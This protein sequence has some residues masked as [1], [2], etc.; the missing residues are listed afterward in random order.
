MS[1][2]AYASLWHRLCT[3]NFTRRRLSRAALECFAAEFASRERALVVHCVDIDHRRHFPNSFVVS[4]RAGTEPDLRADPAYACLGSIEEGS[5]GLI[6]CT[7]LLEHIAEPAKLVAQ[8]A[9][10]LRP[11][12]R[13]VLSA[14]AVFPF[15]GAPDNFYHYTPNGFRYLFRDWR[16]ISVLR[17]SSGPFL[18][19]AILLQRIN[20]QCEVFPAVRL[21]NEVLFR[22][23]PPLD[24]LVYRQFDSMRTGPGRS[25]VDSMMP[26]M[27]HA[28]IVR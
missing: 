8:F 25:E 2:Q 9:R 28:V 14:S 12:G 23:L 13:L 24:R 5:F 11:G 4:S 3:G 17:G 22:L 6:V 27:L 10:I 18:T 1:R 21:L 26:A 7:G 19:V 20:L 16:D 15:H